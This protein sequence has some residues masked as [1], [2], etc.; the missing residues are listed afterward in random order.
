[1]HVATNR[2]RRG[3]DPATQA[4]VDGIG[5]HD[6]TLISTRSY[7]VQ[8]SIARMIFSGVFERYPGLRVVSTEHEVAWA[9][10]LLTAMDYNYTQRARENQYRY[11][12]DALPSDFFHSNVSLSF[13]EDA[14]GMQLR[15]FIG[16]DN[17]MWG[18]DYPHAESTFPRSREI[19]DQI[20]VGVPEDE[21]ARI[22]GLNAKKLFSFG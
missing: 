10:H 13:Q 8:V 6:L 21:Q 5:G 19:L 4:D 17:L 18:S 20:F 14:I 1:M 22:A 11:K 16:V 15:S 2:G 12:T 3:G 7:W 9:A